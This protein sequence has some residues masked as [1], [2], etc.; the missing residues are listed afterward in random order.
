M[1]TL[2]GCAHSFNSVSF[3]LYPTEVIRL[4]CAMLGTIAVNV[5]L[6]L[7]VSFIIPNIAYPDEMQHNAD[8]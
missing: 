7:K 1:I 4:K 3:L 6:S 5:F 8:F 2:F